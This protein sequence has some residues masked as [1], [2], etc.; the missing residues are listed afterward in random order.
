M[1]K[2]DEILKK[3]EGK[4]IEEMNEEFAQMEM[5]LTPDE[6]HLIISKIDS[7]NIFGGKS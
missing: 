1:S 6:E 4:S 7:M 2:V 3:V 5:E